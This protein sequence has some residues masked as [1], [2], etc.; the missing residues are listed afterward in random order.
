MTQ[1]PQDS[2][3]G[4]SDSVKGSAPAQNQSSQQSLT[5]STR[6]SSAAS[7]NGGRARTSSD[8][9]EQ[10]SLGIESSQTLDSETPNVKR[11]SVEGPDEASDVEG[12]ED[13]LVNESTGA[14]KERP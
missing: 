7:E 11:S 10:D 6:E 4:P 13:S 12:A 5:G 8:K 2:V 9:V 1:K 3:S 14:F